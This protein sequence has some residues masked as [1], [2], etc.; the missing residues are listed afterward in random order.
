[1]CLSQHLEVEFESNKH[2]P[3]E[4]AKDHIH[5]GRVRVQIKKEDGSPLNESITSR[6]DTQMNTHLRTLVIRTHPPHI[7]HVIY[8]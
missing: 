4:P 8:R 6:K 1:M 7:A 2:Y 3:R 5:S